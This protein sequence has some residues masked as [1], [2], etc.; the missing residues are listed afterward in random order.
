MLNVQVG[1][2]VYF[3]IKK[4]SQVRDTDRDCLPQ[5]LSYNFFSLFLRSSV[6]F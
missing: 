3:P 4:R 5:I 2:E 6:K 1:D